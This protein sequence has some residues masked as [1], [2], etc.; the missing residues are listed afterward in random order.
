MYKKHSSSDNFFYKQKKLKLQKEVLYKGYTVICMHNTCPNKPE[1]PARIANSP[2]Q[3]MRIATG[4]LYYMRN[5]DQLINLEFPTLA[6]HI[7]H[8]FNL[9]LYQTT[10]Y[11][12]RRQLSLHF[13]RYRSLF[14]GSYM[15]R[16]LIFNM[17]PRHILTDSNDPIT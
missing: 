8:L 10:L 13:H 14:F 4:C 7:K 2:K 17:R 5:L 11:Q 1:Y 3:V 12:T 9:S 16:S 15:A 6:Q